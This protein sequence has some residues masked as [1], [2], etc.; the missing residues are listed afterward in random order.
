MRTYILLPLLGLLNM[1]ADAATIHNFNARHPDPHSNRAMDH[2]YNAH[3]HTTTRRQVHN[4]DFSGS[5]SSANSVVS[6][7]PPSAETSPDSPTSGSPSTSAPASAAALNRRVMLADADPI[8]DI[9]ETVS[10]ANGDVVD[11][12][13][14]SESADMDVKKRQGL[15][16]VELNVSVRVYSVCRA[17]AISLLST[18][19]RISNNQSNKSRL[20]PRG[21][22][23]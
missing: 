13:A 9:V 18:I 5:S 20:V 2:R 11:G 16:P 22:S 19:S 23:Q 8:A 14:E 3:S 10:D 1:G 4:A 6:V 7:P 12:Q 21:Q 17:S 15:G